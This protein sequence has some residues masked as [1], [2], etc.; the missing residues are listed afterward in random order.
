MIHRL[1]PLLNPRSIAFVGASSKEGRIGGMPISLITRYG[2]EGKVFPVNPKYEEVFGLPCYTDIESI[3]QP[4]DLAVLAI[5]ASD[6]LAMLKRCHAVGVKAAIVYAAGFAEEGE[7]G[8][9]LQNEVELFADAS[10]MA[11]AGPNCMGFANLNTQA[12]TAFASVFNTSSMQQGAG[13]VSLLTQSGNVCAAVYGLLRQLDVPVSHF[14]NT[15]N[16][17]CVEFSEY[18]EYLAEDPD[19]D[20]VVGYIEQ[21]RNGPRFLAACETLR[22][23]DKMLI[24][25]K[26][27]TT[28]K[29]AAAVQSH[30]SALAGDRRVYQ[31]VFEQANVI[32]ANDFAQMALLAQLA[33]LRHRTAGRR[34][35]VIT[36]S[37][38]LGAILADRFIDAGLDLPD[39]P[40][41]VQAVLRKGIPDYG[42]VGNPVDVT[43][44]VVNNPGF[45]HEV[46]AVL[47]N[48]DALDA[49]VIYAP[50][51]MLDRM[52]DSIAAVAAEYPR[53]MAAIDTGKA[54]TRD[55]L[56]DAG[57][58]V[59]DDLGRAVSALGPFLLWQERRRCAALSP[60][61]KTGMNAV[62]PAQVLVADSSAFPISTTVTETQALNYLSRFGVP[63]K[64]MSS[65]H[66]LDDARVQAAALGYPVVLKIV[67][68][69]IA[70]KTEVG[71]V[72]LNVRTETELEQ[73]YRDMMARIAQLAP[74]AR[75]EGV[76]VQKMETSGVE[77]IVGARRDPVFG[78]MLTVGLGGVL[79]ELYQD[80]R[81]SLLPVNAD[82]VQALLREL[83]AFPLLDGYRNAPPADL[84]A[85]CDAIVALGDA[86]VAAPANVNEVEVNPLLVRRKGDGAVALDALIVTGN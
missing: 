50:G 44:N 25:L 7:A 36:M 60:A 68:P 20:V 19:T 41:D 61:F 77:L 73:K 23:R 57:V 75:L 11:V 78:P 70:H 24:A 55:M 72:V 51:Y 48:T 67:S 64:E 6:V 21:L 30:T 84:A 80:V 5:A 52:A 22:Q 65:A 9:A 14:I 66:S 8:A 13:H 38:A 17:A 71:G 31:A 40:A 18:L 85:A 49:V 12:H 76:L 62:A 74:E 82:R 79:T 47:A 45:V 4:V 43:G 58:A 33:R 86:M 63:V 3:P 34:V 59:F 2:Y 28:A 39:L 54:A 81:H 53:F 16:E 37:G 83:I 35:A 46:L 29:G 15:G 69:D 10:G 27:G 32:E 42:M 1:E 26:A 56:R